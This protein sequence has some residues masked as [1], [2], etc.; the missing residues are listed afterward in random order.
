MEFSSFECCSGNTVSSWL[1]HYKQLRLELSISAL[2]VRVPLAY[3]LSSVAC[4]LACF[5]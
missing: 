4:S 3:A 1:A 2:L 5:T